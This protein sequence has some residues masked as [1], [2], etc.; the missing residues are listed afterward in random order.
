VV[1]VEDTVIADVV[2]V[3][4][5][6][7]LSELL[8]EYAEWNPVDL[9]DSYL[10]PGLIDF[11][12]RRSTDWESLEDMTQAAVSG[13]ITLCLQERNLTEASTETGA[14]YC[15][16]GLIAVLDDSEVS[17]SALEEAVAVKGYLTPPDHSTN[18]VFRL[19]EWLQRVALLNL[20][21]ILDP[22]AADPKVLFHASPCRV[23]PPDERARVQDLQQW[24]SGRTISSGSESDGTSS[25]EEKELQS[26]RTWQ[27]QYREMRRKKYR[28]TENRVHSAIEERTFP[29]TSGNFQMMSYSSDISLE[30]S[31]EPGCMKG[32]RRPPPLA[33]ASQP[34]RKSEG[35]YIKQLARYPESLEQRG[36]K[37]ILQA[38]GSSPLKVHIPNLSSP[39]AIALVQKAK[40]ERITCETCPHFLFFTDQQ[41]ADGDTRFKS[42]PP[43]RNKANCN[44]LWDLVKLN[45]VDCVCSQHRSVPAEFKYRPD[46]RKAVS[47]I[48]GLGFTLQVLWTL[49]KSPYMDQSSCEHF[50]V[51][52]AKW[53]SANPAQ[54]LGLPQRG[55]IAKGCLADLVVWDPFEEVLVEQSKAGQP[56][57]CPYLGVKLFGKVQRVYVGG[58][59]AYDQG[60]VRPVA[61]KV[62][63][64]GRVR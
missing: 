29:S 50:L 15:D 9:E 3:E 57:Q 23:L 62:G 58:E 30:L 19:P 17:A 35:L 37:M 45:A 27:L 42:F 24:S 55:S 40:D 53:T 39:K 14:R 33:V 51:S 31:F 1:L 60:T 38:L 13:G 21:V 10:S 28:R 7:P 22:S 26:P 36:V 47:G 44:F 32:R 59:L 16:T 20:P 12:V 64:E 56:L 48:C 46:F 5:E 49:L 11:N 63:R 43:I 34:L 18:A 2:V 6:K 61:R 4:K 41:I 54:V 8:R 52:I 25:S